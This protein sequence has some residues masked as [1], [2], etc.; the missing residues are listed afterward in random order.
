MRQNGTL[1]LPHDL[2]IPILVPVF[3]AEILILLPPR[4][5]DEQKAEGVEQG[6]ER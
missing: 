5:Q 1:V 6:R 2:T 4:L 3:A